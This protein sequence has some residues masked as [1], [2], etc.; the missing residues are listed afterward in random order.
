M[1][2]EEKSRAEI[3]RT[4]RMDYTTIMREIKRGLTNPAGHEPDRQE[5]YC[6]ETV[7]RKYQKRLRAKR[8]DS[9][10]EEDHELAKYTEDK[11]V[12]DGYSP[13]AALHKTK[14]DGLPFSVTLSKWIV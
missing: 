11:I 6:A 13:E 3:A 8:P 14:E 5:V 4:L 1:L 9:K 7:E 12:D 2:K 10:L